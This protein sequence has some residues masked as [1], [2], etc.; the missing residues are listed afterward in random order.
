[1]RRF[2]QGRETPPVTCSDVPP[3]SVPALV[4]AQAAQRP[5]ALAVTSGTQR[6]TYGE[7]DTRAGQLASRL[8]SMGVGRDVVVGLCLPRS[9]D[10]VV[11]A[12]GILKAGGAY[13]PMDP[14][15]P[16]DRLAVIVNDA[17][18]PV[19]ISTSSL[20]AQLPSGK[21]TV[22]EIDTLDRTAGPDVARPPDI[23]PRDLA[24]VIY[25]SGST[26]TPKGVDLT[27]GGLTN[28][29][30]WHIRAFSVSAADRASHVAGL[31]FDAAVW[32][33]WPYLVAGAS[34][35]LV[36]DVTRNS[37]EDLRT[38]LVAQRVTVAF[39]P[40]PLAE[41]M[42]TPAPAWPPETALRILLTGG[43][44]LHHHPPQGLPFQLVNNYGPTEATVVAT[45]GAVMPD[46]VPRTR[47]PIGLAIPNTHV[48]ILDERMQPV[49]AGT[50]GEIYI[51]GAG[52]ARG[53]RNRPDLTAERFVADPYSAEP[54]GRLYRTGDLGRILPDGQIAFLGR[55]DDQIKI[56]GYRIEP[57]EISSVLNE[58]EQIVTSL[59]VAREDDP[60]DKRLV[61]YVVLAGER[62][63]THSA[64]RGFLADR[65]PAYML[66][67]AFVRL[68][69]FPLTPHGKVDRAALPMPSPINT[70]KDDHSLGLPSGTEWRVAEI[71]CELLHLDDI[72]L[73][74][75]F[76]LLGG[77]SLLGAQLIGRLREAF[78]VRISLRSLFDAPTVAALAAE[79]ER[80]AENDGANAQ[81]RTQGAPTGASKTH[82]ERA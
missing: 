45:S 40:T 28:L 44:T 6:L 12:L 71:L 80:L 3:G 54:G 50:S 19:V 35:H 74:D 4:A 42:L 76:F 30:S 32:E 33:L 52:L 17:D 25:T 55:L 5:D 66:P 29:V 38:W 27:H 13:V 81:I 41:R 67:V 46:V 34:V 21:R 26:G 79:V 61:A 64:L 39:V 37:A 36:D 18:T 62:E 20:A 75:N 10:M 16:R 69:T 59:V 58:H 9:L 60:G 51:G 22:L 53:Y 24:Y 57:G 8:Q 11:G 78:G 77:H 14:A 1:M 72:D 15:Y 73:D 56:R 49:P 48:R 2:Y 23:T 68:D 70:L 31:G 65:L 82:A 47:P 63:P 7:L 43:D